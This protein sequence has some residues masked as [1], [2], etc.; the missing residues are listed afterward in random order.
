MTM[1]QISEHFEAAAKSA[2]CELIDNTD[3]RATV[4]RHHGVYIA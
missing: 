2:D 4:R 1:A 3:T